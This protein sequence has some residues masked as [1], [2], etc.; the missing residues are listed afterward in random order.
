MS[1]LSVWAIVIHT[2]DMYHEIRSK[3]AMKKW[4]TKNIH[5]P[6]LMHLWLQNE[7]NQMNRTNRDELT[8]S[9]THYWHRHTG[10]NKTLLT[11]SNQ[12]K[13]QKH[14]YQTHTHNRHEMEPIKRLSDTPET[15]THTL[16]SCHIHFDCMR[17]ER[18][19]YT[20]TPSKRWIIIWKWWLPVFVLFWLFM[21]VYH[22]VFSINCAKKMK[23]KK[24]N[25]W[26]DEKKRRV[27]HTAECKKCKMYDNRQI[28]LLLCWQH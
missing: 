16:S 13:P 19:L 14:S 27:T 7:A 6:Q 2:D 3:Q 28:L 8:H 23:E 26:N 10:R 17:C 5:M 24:T 22:V 1:V 20:Y 4:K 15:H 11:W 25:I 9:R 18:G 12:I 21:N